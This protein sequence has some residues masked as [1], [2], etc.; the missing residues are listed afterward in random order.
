MN[1]QHTNEDVPHMRE[2]LYIFVTKHK[3]SRWPSMISTQLTQR[4]VNLNMTVI[5]MFFKILHP[6][7]AIKNHYKWIFL[8]WLKNLFIM[9]FF[10]FQK[11]NL[12][13]EISKPCD[14][15]HNSI[16]LITSLYMSI[17]HIKRTSNHFLIS[18]KL[19][20]DTI[21]LWTDYNRLY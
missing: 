1:D 20:I 6:L 10:F 12:L 19:I 16:F 7:Y 18:H 4:A 8:L 13:I 5:N 9:R 17:I 21:F 14:Q 3:N 15:H 2:M 11:R